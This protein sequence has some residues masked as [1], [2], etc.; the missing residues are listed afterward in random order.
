MAL[1]KSLPQNL[2]LISTGIKTAA[3]IAS[4]AVGVSPE[5]YWKVG[6]LGTTYS[7]VPYYGMISSPVAMIDFR[8][9]GGYINT[10]I[11]GIPRLDGASAALRNK[12]LSKAGL[13]A[14]TSATTGAYILFGRSS[15]GKFG[16]GWGDHGSNYAPKLDFTSRSNVN[17]TWSNG[18]WKRTEFSPTAALEKITPFRGDKVSVIDFKSK[19]NLS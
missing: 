11:L 12:V 10:G 15:V 5:N 1:D 9:M 13:Y 2:D 4:A 18:E 6:D 14:A 16:K 19:T 3:H 8:A 17:K 7:T